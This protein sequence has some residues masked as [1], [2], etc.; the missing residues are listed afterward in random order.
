[1]SADFVTVLTAIGRRRATKLIEPARDTSVWPYR[2]IPGQID[3]TGYD[4][5]W[6][7]KGEERQVGSIYDLAKLLDSLELELSSFIVRG[8]IVDGVDRSRMLRRVRTRD[9]IDPT[10]LA[11]EH[12]WIALDLDAIPCPEYI[13]PAREPKAAVEHVID[14]HLPEEFQG[15]TCRWQFTSSQGF[16]GSTI[17]LRLFYWADR[18]LSDSD[19]KSWLCGHEPGTKDRRWPMIDGAVF[20]PAQP[21]YTAAPLIVGMRDPIPQ[22]SGMLFGDTD[23][24]LAPEIAPEHRRSA[25]SGHGGGSQAPGEPGLGYEGHCARIGDHGAGAG[26]YGPIKSAVASYIARHGSQVDTTWLRSDL[27]EVIRRAPRDPVKHPDDYIELRVDDLDPLIIAIV[28]MER[29]REEAKAEL[30]REA[31]ERVSEILEAATG[32]KAAADLDQEPP[33]AEF[34][35]PAFAAPM[36]AQD[37]DNFLTMVFARLADAVVGFRSL[38][39]EWTEAIKASDK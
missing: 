32:H 39:T 33:P 16:K 7:F 12:Y 13:D 19:L 8:R 11:A 22:R 38:T 36:N 3:I 26:F 24:V 2:K 4:T 15:V 9:D 14:R 10:L 35:A 1:M 25:Y 20:A 30:A 23:E 18:P 29:A 5:M 21:V 28:E 37:Y 17:S 6:T 34:I 27:E 31:A